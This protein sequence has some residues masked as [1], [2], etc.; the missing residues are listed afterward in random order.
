MPNT[1][2]SQRLLTLKRNEN[3]GPQEHAQHPPLGRE[4][5]V[6][7]LREVKNKKE[8]AL[9]TIEKPGTKN[10]KK[11]QKKAPTRTER[12]ITI[13]ILQRQKRRR[14][15]KTMGKLPRLKKKFLKTKYSDKG[16][17]LFGSVIKATSLSR[18]KV[19]HFLHTEPAYPKYRIV[20]RKT[21]RLKVIVYDI[22][23]I[24]SLDLAFVDKLAQYNHDVKYLPV[25]VDCMYR[26][27]RVQPLK[28]KYATTTAEAFKLMITTKQ[29]QKVR[30]DK[31]TEFKGSFEALCKNERHKHI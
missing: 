25:A 28:S 16:L 2:F 18:K 20:I 17:A 5:V 12:P 24:W 21:P 10:V 19:K 4:E 11:I 29:P 26:Y 1:R 14:R 31:G 13:Q 9:A 3:P 23:E 8:K 27:L 15:K 22:D 30:V 7:T 6:Q